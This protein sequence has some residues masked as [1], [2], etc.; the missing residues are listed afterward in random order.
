[1]ICYLLVGLKIS[2]P[3]NN[4]PSIA[5]TAAL[6]KHIAFLKHIAKNQEIPIIIAI[7]QDNMRLSMP[8]GHYY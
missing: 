7:F 2:L 4:K 3:G 1:M 8:V 5:G 6:F